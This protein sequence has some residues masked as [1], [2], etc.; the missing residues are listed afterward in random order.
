ASAVALADDLRRFQAGEPILARPPGRLA[1][2]WKWCK[3]NPGLAATCTV[4]A[5]GLGAALAF[6]VLYALSRD[7]RARD[8]PGSVRE[9][10]EALREKQALLR[11]TELRLAETY[12]ERGLSLCERGEVRPGVV[13][14]ARALEAAPDDAVELADNLRANLAG[15]GRLLSPLRAA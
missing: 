4:A 10:A 6:S 13:W 7:H 3:R 1:R 9:Q 2:A 14:L 12:A 11:T 15:W 8:L 5:L